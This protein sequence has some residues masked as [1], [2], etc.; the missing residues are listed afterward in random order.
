V[1]SGSKVDVDAPEFFEGQPVQRAAGLFRERDD[2]SDDMVGLAEGHAL[3]DEVVGEVRG[4]EQ[5][6]GGCG[7][8]GLGRTDVFVEHRTHQTDAGADGVGGVEQRVPCPPAGR[9]CRS[10]GDPSAGS[11]GT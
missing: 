8:A 2:R 3:A 10:S 9:G 7:A 1:T 4:E 5:G 6:I 11:A